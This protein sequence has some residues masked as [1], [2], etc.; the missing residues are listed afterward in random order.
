MKLATL[1]N[2]SRDGRLIVVS[3]DQTRMATCSAYSTLQSA[4]DNW[5]EAKAALYAI[6]DQLNDSTSFG[7][8]F[9]IQRCDSPLPRAYQFLD[10]STYIKHVE[11]MSGKALPETFNEAPLM[12][13]GGCDTALAPLADILVLDEAWGIDFEAEVVVITDDVPMGTTVDQAAS[14]IQLVMLMNDV[15]YRNFASA[16]RAKGFG[17]IHAK[18]QR[19]FSPF[20]VTPDELGKTWHDGMLH[21]MLCCELN[22]VSVGRLNASI[23]TAFNFP[24]LIAHAAKTRAL[25]AGTIIGGGTVSNASNADDGHGVACLVEKRAFEISENGVA[26][27][28]FMKDGDRIRI[29]AEKIDSDSELS[30]FGEIDQKVCLIT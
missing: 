16:E 6:F 1:K 5:D 14:H 24:Q 15:S 30:T 29:Y 17:F 18:G 28:L 19:A 3:R 12:Y 8:A 7:V 21:M 22:G 27:T 26:K 13:Q 4:L 9:D 10:G 23:G 20:A 11:L 2:A 25:G